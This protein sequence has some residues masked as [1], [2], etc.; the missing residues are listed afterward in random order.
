[1]PK[2]LHLRSMS[3]HHVVRDTQEPA[4]I[5]A[6]GEACSIDLLNQL[7]EWSPTVMVLDG[8][9]QRVLEL[10]IKI[11]IVLGDFDREHH[12]EQFLA[13]QQPV[14]IIHTP[15]QNKTD[16]EKG[17]DLLL[18]RN[19]KAINI[20]WATGRRADHTINNVTNLVRYK[21]EATLVMYDDYSK[22]YCLPNS[23]DKWYVKGTPISLIPIGVVK[24]ITTHGLKYNLHNEDLAIGFK[25]GSSNEALVDGT[26]SIHYQEGNL[27][28]MEC[29]DR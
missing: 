12:P 27:L 25:S 13:H 29:W 14:E 22:I 10:G 4:L 11:D 8:A 26:I 7:L 28:M 6:N 18:S 17:I 23:F 9:L 16:L 20:L 15:D 1:M 24:G 5:I 2:I 19:H 21:D 3:S